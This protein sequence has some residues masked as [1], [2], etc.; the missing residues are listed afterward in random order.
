[1]TPIVSVPHLA[2]LP[3]PSSEKSGQSGK[4]LQSLDRLRQ[5]PPTQWNILLGQTA[6][7]GFCSSDELVGNGRRWWVTGAALDDLLWQGAGPGKISC[8]V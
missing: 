1:M 5:L 3:T 4:P 6:G 8:L 2:S 7:L